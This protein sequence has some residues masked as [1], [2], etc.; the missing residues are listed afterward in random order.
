MRF[1]SA[2][3]HASNTADKYQ[4][5]YYPT[6]TPKPA[7]YETCVLMDW[8]Y[9]NFRLD[10]ALDTG[11]FVTERPVKYST[12]ADTVKLYPKE[13]LYTILPNESDESTIQRTYDLPETLAAPIK[14]GDVVGTVTLSLAGESIGTVELIAG[15]NIDRNMVLYVIS[16]IGEFFSSLYFR[17]LLVLVAI[18]AVIY[19]VLF[20]YMNF[21]HKSDGKI[22]HHNRY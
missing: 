2:V 12:Q 16:R 21:T 5:E 4:Q 6:K 20:L 11:A 22:R 10:N 3:L 1:V 15:S 17:V 19:L 14:Q 7:L 8:V 13:G 18:T 9:N